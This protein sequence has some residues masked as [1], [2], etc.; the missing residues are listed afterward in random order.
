[1]VANAIKNSDVQ[2]GHTKGFLSNEKGVKGK[3]A[4]IFDAESTSCIKVNAKK[5]G[6]TI[7]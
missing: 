7:Y 4:S 3:D 2:N 5:K 1:M 6:S